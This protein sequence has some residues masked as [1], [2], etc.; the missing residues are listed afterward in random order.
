MPKNVTDDIEAELCL[1]KVKVFQVV[2]Y[3]MR[4][5]KWM[6]DLLLQAMP[7]RRVNQT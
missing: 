2:L 5:F 7:A 6:P 1:V 3:L 4:T